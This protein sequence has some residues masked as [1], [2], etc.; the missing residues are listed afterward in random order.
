M[1]LLLLLTKYIVVSGQGQIAMPTA[2][3]LQVFTDR[4]LYIAGE[5]VFFTAYSISND[6]PQ[7]ISLIL[8]AEIISPEGKRTSG[9][10]FLIENKMAHGSLLIPRDNITGNYYLR[11][12]T[13]YM[14]NIGPWSYAYC[15]IRI[16]NPYRE[17]IITGND[18]VLL[19]KQTGGEGESLTITT[20]KNEY[21]P[22]ELIQVTIFGSGNQPGKTNRLSL[23]VAPEMASEE[24]TLQLPDQDRRLQQMD[25]YPETRGISITGKLIDSTGDN[26][27]SGA[28]VNLSIIGQGRDFMAIQTDD[29]GRYF[30]SLPA[31]R[32]YRDLF[33]CAAKTSEVRPRILV[34]NDFCTSPIQLPSPVFILTPEERALAFQMAKNIRIQEVF[35]TEKP[36]ETQ[37]TEPDRAFYGKPSYVLYL[38]E[39]VLLPVLEEYFNELASMVKVRKRNGEKYFKV[40]GGR[41]EMGIYDPLVL[42]DWVAVDDPSK[43]LAASPGNIDRIEMINEPYI[44]GDITFGGII[45]I[46][47]KNADFAGI[48]LPESGIFINYL[49]LNKLSGV[50][51]KPSPSA[52]IP[53][54]RN[55]VFWEPSLILDE[56]NKA[57][58]SI[59]APDTPGRYTIVLKGIDPHGNYIYQRKV[60]EVVEN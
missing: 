55:T 22:R 46:I 5:E 37:T 6:L 17:D 7:D 28:R 24:N 52:N 34:D 20:D 18:T 12:Y 49:F 13:K 26:A 45:S 8:Y 21:Y 36:D 11:V 2:E 59:T 38:D 19:P 14:R 35:N 16:V 44:K 57:S 43:I 53:D 31:Y 32:G 60:V 4:E 56:D 10:K 29:S 50:P 9:G 30:F 25:F 40:L 42:I 47:S 15:G 33:L 3:R 1:V 58:I 48:D 27:I 51:F 39:Y 23:A 41:P 54:T